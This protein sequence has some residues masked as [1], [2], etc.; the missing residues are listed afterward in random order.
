MLGVEYER[1]LRGGAL[2]KP[3]P[4]FRDPQSSMEQHHPSMPA[5]QAAARD[6][7]ENRKASLLKKNRNELR[8]MSVSPKVI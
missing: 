5:I 8:M 1:L 6:N 2:N 7:L 4:L 3:E